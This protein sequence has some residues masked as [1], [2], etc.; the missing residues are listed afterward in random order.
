MP[1]R[2]RSRKCVKR[3]LPRQLVNRR[4]V[5]PGFAQLRQE[6]LRQVRVTLDAA[7]PAVGPGDANRSSASAASNDTPTN[8]PAIAS[9]PATTH[10]LRQLQL[11]ADDLTS[12]I[13]A[14]RTTNTEARNRRRHGAGRVRHG[15][16][17]R[18]L[19]SQ[20]HCSWLSGSACC[21]CRS[22]T[23]PRGQVCQWCPGVGFAGSSATS[24]RGAVTQTRGT[25]AAGTSNASAASTR[26]RPSGMNGRFGSNPSI[27]ARS[28]AKPLPP[29]RHGPSTP[30]GHRAERVATGGLPS[31]DSLLRSRRAHPAR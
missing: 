29:R 21:V 19:L 9:T 15:R 17:V 24:T 7:R 13:G 12:E 1:A 25:M 2:S 3:I 22:C 31:R 30:G 28:P 26:R 18:L 6:G 4:L 27:G 16:S 11:V 14:A 10:M 5:Y 23:K 20:R 8:R